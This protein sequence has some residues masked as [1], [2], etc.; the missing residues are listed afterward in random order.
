ML[1]T[2]AVILL[3]LWALGL[4]SSYSMGGLIHIL[5]VIAL[6]P[7]RHRVHP[8]ASGVRLRDVILRD[9][10]A[11][12]LIAGYTGHSWEA[13]FADWLYGKGA[14]KIRWG[15]PGAWR[16]I[17]CR[18]MARIHAAMRSSAFTPG[19]SPGSSST[20]PRSRC[21]A[22]RRPWAPASARSCPARC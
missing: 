5:L 22:A 8:R 11:R 17:G 6:M 3:V 21:P 7:F 9:R 15:T 14:A 19:W 18:A 16:R 20:N 4:V 2:I 12:L 1:E 13:F 10:E